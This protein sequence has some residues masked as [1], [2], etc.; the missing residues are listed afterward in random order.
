MLIPVVIFVV[1]LCAGV[2][3]GTRWLPALA[4]GV[5]GGLAFFVV[6]GLL[7]AALALVGLHVYSI[8]EDVNAFSGLK[9]GEVV[10]GGLA[11][12]LWESGSL[13]GVAAVVY[14]L[15]PRGEVAEGSAAGPAA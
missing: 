2:V 4:A 7:G 13:A 10:A 5:V 15:A 6:C 3:A 14:L 12:M 9:H 1:C 11:S 8:V